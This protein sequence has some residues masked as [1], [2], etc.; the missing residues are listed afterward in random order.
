MFERVPLSSLTPNPGLAPPEEE[1]EEE[2]AEK[3]WG[4]AKLQRRD[5]LRRQ[6]LPRREQHKLHS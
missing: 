5:G 3:E 6:K 2:E 1:E 4:E